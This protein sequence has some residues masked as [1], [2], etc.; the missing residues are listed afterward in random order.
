MKKIFISLSLL[1]VSFV[2]AQTGDWYNYGEVLK[3]DIGFNTGYY[4]TH[5]FPDSTVNVDY[6]SGLGSVW[7]HSLGQVMDPYSDVFDN[8]IAGAVDPSIG[9][10]VDSINFPYRYSGIKSGLQIR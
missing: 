8:S 6:S 2:Q 9:Y 4:R 5:I 7:M 3:Y 10:T 1:A